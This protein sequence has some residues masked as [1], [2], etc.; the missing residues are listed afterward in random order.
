MPII[1]TCLF[2]TDGMGQS[3][4]SWKKGIKKLLDYIGVFFNYF[5]LTTTQFNLITS[6]TP[7]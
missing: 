6:D 2:N 3:D 1:G 4:E 7:I 5:N